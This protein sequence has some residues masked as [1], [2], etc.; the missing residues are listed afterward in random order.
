MC[1]KELVIN[2]KK[3][4]EEISNVETK[5]FIKRIGLTPLIHNKCVSVLKMG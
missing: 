5:Y 3:Q 4:V 2:F 1:S